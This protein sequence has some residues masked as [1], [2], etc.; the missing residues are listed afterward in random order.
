[1]K[2]DSLRAKTCKVHF[3]PFV[4]LLFSSVFRLRILNFTIVSKV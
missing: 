3:E 2:S 4:F 1:M